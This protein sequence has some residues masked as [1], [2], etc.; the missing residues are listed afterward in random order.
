MGTRPRACS[1]WRS[2]RPLQIGRLRLP[3]SLGGL[4]V[5]FNLFNEGST[6][7]AFCTPDGNVQ[8]VQAKP[9]MSARLDIAAAPGAG[10]LCCS[11]RALTSAFCRV[12]G[13]AL[14][15]DRH[16]V[17]R[18]PKRQRYR[19]FP[20]EFGPRRWKRAAELAA[21]DQQADALHLSQACSACF[22][23]LRVSS[24]CPANM[25]N[26]CYPAK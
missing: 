17:S 13:R 9:Y 16:H 15:L 5:R 6:R 2:V 24:C 22:I 7:A 23:I 11:E 4:L 8:H 12:G 19:D 1:C 18:T 20:A 25:M 3:A 21:C 10:S 26:S 14:L